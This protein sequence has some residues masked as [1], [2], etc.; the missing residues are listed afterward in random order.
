MDFASSG[1]SRNGSFDA[2]EAMAHET[3]CDQTARANDG[4]N[5]A[6]DDRVGNDANSGIGGQPQAISA[7]QVA[8]MVF[9]AMCNAVRPMLHIPLRSQHLCPT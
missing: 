3:T 1:D 7:I 5:N 6:V 9:N 2:L 8:P 4:S